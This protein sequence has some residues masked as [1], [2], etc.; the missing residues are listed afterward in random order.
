[1]TPA[2]S[3]LALLA[4]ASLWPFGRGGSDDENREPTID[5]L[6]PTD[7][8]VDT[9]A[10]IPDS[11]ARAIE[12]Y[13]LFIDLVGDD[14]LLHA[15]AMR[16]L[17]DLQLEASELDELQR[18]VESVVERSAGAV[19]LYEALLSSYPR[20][21][22]NDLV[23]YQLA[24][25][26][27]LE[28]NPD[29]A[30]DA[31]DRLVTEYP[32]T[33]HFAEAH[34]R[35][36]EILFVQRRYDE[37]ERAYAA[38][39]ASSDEQFREQSLY[40]EGWALFKQLRYAD[41]LQPFF[42][43]LDRKLASRND[44]GNSDPADVYAVLG[45]ADQEL[46]DDTFRVVS[47]N[48]SY[49]A[50]PGS[51]TSYFNDNGMRPYAYLVYEHLGDL[52]LENER[53]QDAA[54]AYAAFA[55]LDAYHARA[56]L[57]QARVIGAYESG[58]FADLVLDAKR[59]W[60]ERYGP[61][62]LYWQRFSYADQPEVV[63]YLKAN[64]M[65]L[66]AYYHAD[67]Q[68]T[69]SPESYRLAARWYRNYLAA[70]PGDPDSAHTNFLLAEVLFES[71]DHRAAVVEYERTAYDYPLHA[72]SAEAGYA[73]L[74]TY[75][76]IDATLADASREPWQRL[77]INSALR[78]ANAYPAHAQ[79]NA[80]M[81]DAAENLFALGEVE[82][83]RDVGL[84]L[85]ARRPEAS[86]Q[87]VG[88][89]IVAHSAFDLG[90]FAEAERA[91]IELG[92]FLARDDAERADIVE[93]LA[94][95]VYKQG[96]LARLGFDYATS[97]EH[98]LRVA[99]VAPTSAIVPTARY[100][101]AADLL[102][103]EDW[104]RAIAVLEAFRRDYPGHEYAA[105][106][107]AKLA[108]AYLS[109]GNGVMAASEFERIAAG[110]E[111]ADVRKEALWQ[112]ATLYREGGQLA[113]A[114]RSLARFVELYP[115]PSSAAV[116]AMQQLVDIAEETADYPGRMRWLR[117]LVDADAAA[118][119][120]R[121]DRTRYLAAHAA[122]ELAVPARDA[123]QAAR[124]VAPLQDSLA[125]KR[126]RMEAALNAFGRAADYGVAEV[127]TAAT[128]EIAELYHGLSRDLFESER[129]ADLNE[130]ELDQYEILLEEQ[131]FP[132]EE[133]AI[134]LHEVNAA[135]TAEGVYDES[136]RKSLAALAELLP[137][138]YAKPEMGEAYVVAL[139]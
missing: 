48:F 39:L 125:V 122:F 12:S 128:Y 108:V 131:A 133:Q 77:Q 47:I 21:E 100:D 138:R 124:L 13:K 115:R 116:E 106:V 4:A 135:R 7:I 50:G 36:G 27:E 22:K 41:S 37:A 56:P 16:R 76:A 121:T 32:G 52:Y 136:V 130:L 84:I 95:S 129:P 40:K 119:A 3:V 5:D 9:A 75:D 60:V 73:A 69:K 2:A 78:F 30:L 34:F 72:E 67:A 55:D 80:A 93:R 103:L 104:D 126:E 94:S 86:L 117:A 26:Y 38:V 114:S 109:S 90:R 107:T 53:Y 31:L 98:F 105:D 14:P 96:E 71:G 137:V 113:D 49:V 43:L 46:I 10:T 79:A 23:L 59:A 19:G 110:D 134:E 92:R 8:V 68:S 123:F 25:A 51:V 91:Y 33:P 139:Q 102:V 35:R 15:E 89:T 17:A 81:T 62:S 66:A 70:F 42:G 57:L 88:W 28:G 82:L 99:Q 6:A 127:T 87:R 101:A 58:G 61:T 64:L 1:V 111:P 44:S 24:R 54:A 20:Y 18:N 85:L 97:V 120:E 83:A 63:A 45:R 112:A 11:Q 29:A 65:D 74:V 132:F 118:G